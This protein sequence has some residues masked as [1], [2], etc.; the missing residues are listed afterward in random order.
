[1]N[2]LCLYLTTTQLLEDISALYAPPQMPGSAHLGQGL[3]LRQGLKPQKLLSSYFGE[4]SSL[5]FFVV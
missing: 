5:F 1:M 2:T 4:M 3:K